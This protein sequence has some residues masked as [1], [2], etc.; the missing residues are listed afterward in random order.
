MTPHPDTHLHQQQVKAITRGGTQAAD[1][2]AMEAYWMALKEGKSKEEA[3]KVFSNTY[4]KVLH[5]KEMDCAS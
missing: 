4:I 3:N 1:D 2:Q 5:G